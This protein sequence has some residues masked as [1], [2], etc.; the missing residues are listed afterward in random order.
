LNPASASHIKVSFSTKIKD[1]V[2]FTKTRL[3]FLVVFSAV[4]GFLFA[5]GPHAA[6]DILWLC[7]GGFL[8]TGASNGLNQIFE[9]EADALMKRTQNRPLPTGRMSVTEAWIASIIFGIGGFLALWLGLGM[10]P[11]LL[12]LLSLVMYAFIYTPSKKV[13]PWAVFIGA[14]PGAMPPMLGYI[15]QTGHF[16][17][18]PGLLFFVQFMWQFPHFWAIAWIADEDYRKAGYRLLPSIEGKAKKSSFIIMIYTL[19]L[20]PI[21]LTPWIF[22]LTGTATLIVASLIGLAFY[23]QSLKLHHS[24]RDE[25]A[26][27]LMFYSFAYLPVIQIT[28]VLDKIV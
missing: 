26:K 3:A 23:L 12:G 9:K 10:L 11:A 18:E 16:G 15:A 5:P 14:F 4:L 27:R 8:I 25:D 21:S 17:F 22:E 19:L 6:S 1:Y 28:Y 13:T 2:V 7:V 24:Q 20:V